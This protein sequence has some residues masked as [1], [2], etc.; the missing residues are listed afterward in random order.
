MSDAASV[1]SSA[2]AP[3]AAAAFDRSAWAK[4]LQVGDLIDAN[5]TANVAFGIGRGWYVCRV[6]EA[7]AA[8]LRVQTLY[9]SYRMDTADRTKSFYQ[10]LGTKTKGQ[11]TGP[12]E[13]RTA[14]LQSLTLPSLTAIP[15][16][17]EHQLQRCC[18]DFDWTCSK[19]ATTKIAGLS[20]A[21]SCLPCKYDLCVDCFSADGGVDT[22]PLPCVAPPAER[23]E[24]TNYSDVKFVVPSKELECQ[25]CKATV[26]EPANLL[27]GQHT[28]RQQRCARTP[29]HRSQSELTSAPLCFS[30]ACFPFVGHLACMECLRQKEL[31]TCSVCDVSYD[32]TTL[33]QNLFAQRQIER[34]IV[35]CVN[36][37]DG[38]RWTDHLGPLGENLAAHL[39]TCQYRLFSCPRCEQ[40]VGIGQSAEHV[41]SACTVRE[42]AKVETVV[43]YVTKKIAA[44]EPAE[45]LLA[46]WIVPPAPSAV[47]EHQTEPHVEKKADG[48]GERSDEKSE[49][50]LPIEPQEEKSV[51]MSTGAQERSNE[52]NESESSPIS[53]WSEVEAASSDG[54]VQ[55]GSESTAATTSL[56]SLP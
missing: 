29:Y 40:T 10:P 50:E 28:Q 11:Y 48:A 42:V 2:P 23:V 44:V 8:Q 56:A 21:Y 24:L 32:L 37:E 47:E 6:I 38:C 25:L 39:L 41:Q 20:Q 43:T 36:H 17:P 30:S 19:C 12:P 53:P 3:A 51:A 9:W 14:F 54:S 55:S 49:L 27:C 22:H 35:G 1:S 26:Y 52:V 46:E 16:H 33:Q 15:L 34:Q 13:R 18:F 5:C 31:K 7:T 4:S 45:Q